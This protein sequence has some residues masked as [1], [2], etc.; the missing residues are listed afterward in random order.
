MI[1]EIF[2]VGDQSFFEYS[3]AYRYAKKIGAKKM[4]KITIFFC[5]GEVEDEWHETIRLIGAE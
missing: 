2:W 3:A 1:E 5:C 4:S